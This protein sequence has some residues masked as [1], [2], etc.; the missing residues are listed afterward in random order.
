MPLDRLD[1]VT[2]L[3]SD[4]ERS[5]AFYCE[6]LGMAD[7]DRP[8]F[9]FPGAWLYVEGRPVVHL[10]GGRNKGELSTTGSVDHVAFTARDLDAMRSRL[11]ALKISF[12]EVKVPGRS[13][14]QIFLRDPDGVMIELTFQL[15]P[16]S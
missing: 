3:C 1:H 9:N 8:P 4:V 16:A 6:V 7:G 14:Q 12:R 2:V 5:R 13:L 15:G 10:V 11:E